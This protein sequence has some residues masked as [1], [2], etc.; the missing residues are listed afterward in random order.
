MDSSFI[1]LGN[2]N[3]FAKK[4]LSCKFWLDCQKKWNDQ[5][6]LMWW[7][8]LISILDYD[9]C[10]TEV[11]KIW[12]RLILLIIDWVSV[13][14]K[15]SRANIHGQVAVFMRNDLYCIVNKGKGYSFIILVTLITWLHLLLTWHADHSLFHWVVRL[16]ILRY[17]V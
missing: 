11:K 2:W 9:R 10:R 6:N 1:L 3:N 13:I 14:C 5:N 15:S 4:L 7:A 16:L 17:R 8:W 12:F